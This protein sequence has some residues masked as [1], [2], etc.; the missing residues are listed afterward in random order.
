MPLKILGRG[1]YSR[2][3][4][5]GRNVAI[6]NV[7]IHDS[8]TID[9]VGSVKD[10][11]V[12]F[13]Q[14]T[15]PNHLVPYTGVRYHPKFGGRVDTR[16]LKGR[17]DT[18]QYMMPKLIDCDNFNYRHQNTVKLTLDVIDGRVNVDVKYRY[19]GHAIMSFLRGIL[20]GLVFL[21]DMG[22]VHLDLKPNNVL[23]D[24]CS[25]RY[26][27]CDFDF[28]TVVGD[29]GL[30]PADQLAFTEG[31]APP[32]YL[33]ATMVSRTSDIW[34][35]GVTLYE[36][37]TGRYMIDQR[38]SLMATARDYQSNEHWI[39]LFKRLCPLEET[40]QA[41]LIDVIR[42]C[43][44]YSYTRR[45]TARQLLDRLFASES[46]TSVVPEVTIKQESWSKLQP[47]PK[48][49]PFHVWEHGTALYIRYCQLTGQLPTFPSDEWAVCL[50]II[51]KLTTSYQMIIPFNRFVPF[52]TQPVNLLELEMLIANT[53]M[54]LWYNLRL[55]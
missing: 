14:R 51:H 4:D 6:K 20:E 17:Y 34:S 49:I 41:L 10:L 29:D 9:G 36:V 52:V 3:D 7:I 19:L 31:Y 48:T 39:P 38:D 35:L 8:C 21:N 16:R 28:L 22:F 26:Y 30:H 11:Q 37:A 47:I 23:E 53:T 25:G 12:N 50:Y 27:L 43:L 33:Q 18:L 54:N 44:R 2:V 24:E 55:Q 40:D 5:G 13:W 42:S 15:T 46:P 1:S 45:P 32:E